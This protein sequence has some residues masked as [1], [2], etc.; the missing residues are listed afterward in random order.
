MVMKSYRETDIETYV[1]E[2]AS[3]EPVPGGG[4]TS[5]LAGALAVALCN[6]VAQL[7][8]NKPKYADSKDDIKRIIAEAD[9]LQNELLTLVDK[10]PTAFEPLA[11][12]Y[13]MPKNTPEEIA[14]KERV[15]EEC[16]HVA[17]S[18]P[19]DIMDCCAQTLDL[20]EEI[21]DKGSQLLISDV[22]SAATICK[23]ALE[24]AA[25][26]VLANTQY[27]KDKDY[28][29]ALNTDVARF[30]AD[31]QEKSDKLFDKAYGILL[32]KSLGR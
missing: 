4:S 18:V 7:T 27:M 10:D 6:M 28:A 20:I 5:A 16:L 25:L 17:A 14:E 9:K 13:A 30:L 29:H 19:I 21:I 22:G 1:R 26:S 11:K 24:S 3:S 15:L 23:A 8:V 31:Y 32:R 2:L 12:A